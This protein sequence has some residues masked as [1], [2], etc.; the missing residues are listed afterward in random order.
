[1]NDVKH[2]PPLCPLHGK[3]TMRATCQK[4]NAAYMRGYLS[5]MRKTRPAKAILE[6]AKQRARRQGIPYSLRRQDIVLPTR[7]PVLGL[8]LIVGEAR[9]DASPSLDRIDPAKGY[10]PGNVRV[11]S[12]QANRLKGNRSLGEILRLSQA[13]SRC[14]R[15]EYAAVAAYMEREALLVEVKQKAAREI[16]PDNPWAVVAEFLERKFREFPIKPNK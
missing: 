14:R 3:P 15:S 5:T 4:C 6:R 11:I 2:D 1:M 13:G 7:C 12:D 10:Q 9:S 16:S 8:P